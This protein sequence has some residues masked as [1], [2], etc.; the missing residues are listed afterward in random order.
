VESPCRHDAGTHFSF[1]ATL[2]VPSGG[3]RACARLKPTAPRD[4]RPPRLEERGAYESAL[5]YSAGRFV[6]TPNVR[7]GSKLTQLFP[8]SQDSRAVWQDG[9][10]IGYPARATLQ[11]TGA[12][13]VIFGNFSE[14]LVAQWAGTEIVVDPYTLASA[15]Q[16][17]IVTQLLCDN[18][19]RHS[20]SLCI[21]TN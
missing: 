17:R 20:Q 9:Q 4:R 1:D 11:L 7:A 15:G 19:L 3:F 10:V 12:N 5:C 8:G 18:A 16:I 13:T 2:F 6:T 21:S 14:L